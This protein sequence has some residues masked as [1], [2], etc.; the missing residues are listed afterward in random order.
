MSVW[1]K[2]PN[3]TRTKRAPTGCFAEAS[4]RA[5]IGQKRK[6]R[7]NAS[8]VRSS[9][10]ADI[11]HIPKPPFGNDRSHRHRMGADDPSRPFA[12]PLGQRP[13]PRVQ[14]SSA[15]PRCPTVHRP[16]PPTATRTRHVPNGCIADVSSSAAIGLGVDNH[17]AFSIADIE[18]VFDQLR[19]RH[20]EPIM[21][22]WVAFDPCINDCRQCNSPPSRVRAR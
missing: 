10:T 13:L 18:P 1:P 15:V 11:Q 9:A 21:R 20:F 2:L 6:P 16:K 7:V 5:A 14:R 19:A 4:A 3:A 12:V 22:P 17:L 8:F